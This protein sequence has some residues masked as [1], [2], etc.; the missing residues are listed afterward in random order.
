MMLRIVR[1]IGD[2]QFEKGDESYGRI[3]SSSTELVFSM[4]GGVQKTKARQ[5]SNPD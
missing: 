5:E 3:N 1:P 2:F 4:V